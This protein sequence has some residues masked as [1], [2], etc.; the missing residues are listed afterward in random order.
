MDGLTIPYDLGTLF[1]LDRVV[2][3]ISVLPTEEQ[4][5]RQGTHKDAC[6]VELMRHATIVPGYVLIFAALVIARLLHVPCIES[7]LWHSEGLAR[8][9][10]LPGE[11]VA[12]EGLGRGGWGR[13]AGGRR[14]HR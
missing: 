4:F 11:G 2:F 6:E 5:A 13:R 8:E 9:P 1:L 3:G 12:G 14:V 7:G 10:G